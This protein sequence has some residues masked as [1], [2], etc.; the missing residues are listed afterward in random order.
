MVGPSPEYNL[1]VG[2][3]HTLSPLTSALQLQASGYG[4]LPTQPAL[5]LHTKGIPHLRD[6]M[7]SKVAVLAL[8]EEAYGVSSGRLSLAACGASIWSSLQCTCS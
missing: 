2:G 1:C 6:P 3:T 8:N 5:C 4:H 7:A